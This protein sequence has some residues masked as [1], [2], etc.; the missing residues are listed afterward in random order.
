MLTEPTSFDLRMHIF[1]IPVRVHPSFWIIAAALGWNGE[2]PQL[3]LIWVLC[4]FG[5]ILIHELG[6]ALMAEALGWRSDILLY[7]FGGLAFSDRWA[8]RTPTKDIFV[9]IAGP[10]AQ[11]CLLPLLMLASWGLLQ[12]GLEVHKYVHYALIYLWFINLIWPILNLMPVLPLDGGQIMQSLL[13]LFGV[14]DPVSPA[15]VVS[16]IVGGL[17][18]YASYSLAGG[19]GGMLFIFLTI[20]NIQAY[21]QHRAQRW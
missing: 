4:V 8:G 2:E 7:A 16:I 17:L 12:S 19:T 1:R 20:M 14:R 6:H 3:T 5:S 11:F 21:Q 10:A 9:S 18:A 13:E 15:L